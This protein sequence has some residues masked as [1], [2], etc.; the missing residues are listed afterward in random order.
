MVK[1]EI[2]DE[3]EIEREERWAAEEGERAKEYPLEKYLSAREERVD[4]VGSCEIQ[5]Q[6]LISHDC[7]E[8]IKLSSQLTIFLANCSS[9]KFV[10]VLKALNA[11]GTATTSFPV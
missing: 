8:V 3:R 5:R 2:R 10:L 1:E 4:A 9:S 6:S 7:V 11:L